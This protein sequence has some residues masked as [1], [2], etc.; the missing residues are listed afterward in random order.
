M[1]QPDADAALGG[2]GPQAQVSAQ[3]SMSAIWHGR[4]C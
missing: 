3:Q 1:M 2:E 4:P